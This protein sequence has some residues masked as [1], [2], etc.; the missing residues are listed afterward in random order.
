MASRKSYRRTR[1]ANPIAE[2][3]GLEQYTRG[4]GEGRCR[5]AV[6]R[7]FFNPVGSVHGGILFT[8][9]FMYP[10]IERWITKDDR[11]HHVLDRPQVWVQVRIPRLGEGLV[12]QP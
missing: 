1:R 8:V 5:L 9:M 10:W 7:E 6:R 4:A 2:F 11:E 3:L 12:C